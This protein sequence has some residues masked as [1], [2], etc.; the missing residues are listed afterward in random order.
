[1]KAFQTSSLVLLA[2]VGCGGGESTDYTDG[3]Q[4]ALQAAATSAA[5]T[6]AALKSGAYIEYAVTGD[7]ELTDREEEVVLCSTTSDGFMAHT[8]GSWNFSCMNCRSI[9]A[10]NSRGDSLWLSTG[11]DIPPI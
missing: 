8:I 11:S 7:V 5:D 3:A 1:M 2:F 6:S 9:S 10:S 4:A